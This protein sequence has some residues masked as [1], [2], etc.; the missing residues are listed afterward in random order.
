MLPCIRF[1]FLPV[2]VLL[3]LEENPELRGV[4]C[5]KD[6]L[7]EGFKFK[8]TPGT[9]IMVSLQLQTDKLKKSIPNKRKF[10]NSFN[11]QP[12]RAIDLS[13]S[14]FS[15]TKTGTSMLSSTILFN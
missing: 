3:E 6:L 5:L 10:V 13:D 8:A 11:W 2:Q 15:A 7:Y 1:P 14:G 12:D 4:S 9:F